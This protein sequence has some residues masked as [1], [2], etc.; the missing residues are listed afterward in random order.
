MP[1]THVLSHCVLL[2]TSTDACSHIACHT[3]GDKTAYCKLVTKGGNGWCNCGPDYT[4]QFCSRRVSK[5]VVVL[6]STKATITDCGTSATHAH[7]SAL[8]I[9]P[10]P[11]VK[12]QKATLTANGTVNEAV[13]AAKFTMSVSLDGVRHPCCL[14]P[15]CSQCSQSLPPHPHL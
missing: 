3:A 7:M 9:V 13:T 11:P 4:G 6:G 12:G 8:S 1:R 14:L 2:R 5:N 10:N 15:R